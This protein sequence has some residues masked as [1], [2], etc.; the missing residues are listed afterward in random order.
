M[1]KLLKEGGLRPHGKR[2]KR[3]PW[4]IEICYLNKDEL[5]MCTISFMGLRLTAAKQTSSAYMCAK[6][7]KTNKINKYV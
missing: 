7:T 2:L 1:V 3:S 5:V 6:S 4:L